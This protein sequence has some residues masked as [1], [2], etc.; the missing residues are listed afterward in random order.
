MFE[1]GVKKK[2]R[3]RENTLWEAERLML[4]KPFIAAL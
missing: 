1:G 4:T 3:E 2:I